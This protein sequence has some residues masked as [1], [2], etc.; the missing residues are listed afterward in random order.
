[1]FSTAEQQCNLIIT[2]NAQSTTAPNTL[3]TNLALTI[4][5][6]N[7]A[8]S[9]TT[10]INIQSVHTATILN[11]LNES[12]TQPSV[13]KAI[14]LNPPNYNYTVTTPTQQFNPILDSSTTAVTPTVPIVNL[15]NPTRFM[16]RRYDFK[17]NFNP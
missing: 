11:V 16:F 14:Q 2:P 17:S 15:P 12:N 9:S 7:N 6:T 3:S 8:N 1:M 4:K 5:F 13:I 10:P